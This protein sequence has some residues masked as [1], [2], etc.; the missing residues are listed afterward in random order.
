MKIVALKNLIQPRASH[1]G[2]LQE[3]KFKSPSRRKYIC[4]V[5]VKI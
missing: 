1:E 5:E 4:Y 3:A 2:V